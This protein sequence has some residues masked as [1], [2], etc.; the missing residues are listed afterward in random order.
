MAAVTPAARTVARLIADADRT[1]RHLG[2]GDELA[3][4]IEAAQRLIDH[5]WTRVGEPTP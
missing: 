1:T 2:D 4:L 3:P 5:L